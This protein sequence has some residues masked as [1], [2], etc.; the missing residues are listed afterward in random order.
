MR[1]ALTF[2]I[3]GTKIYHTI[4]DENGS[5]IG[6][7]EKY[8]TPKSLEEIKTIILNAVKKYENEVD[9][10]GISTAGAV[11][12]ENTRV[13]SSTGNLVSNYR[14]FDFQS[15]SKLPVYVENDANCAAWAEHEIGAS[16]NCPYSVMI[17]LGTGVGGG[18]IINNKIYKGKSG[19]AGEMH[20]KMYSDKRRKCTCGAY[21]C[22][23]AYA[24]GTGLKKTAEEMSGNP[25]ITTYDVVEGADKGNQLMKDILAKWQK[26]ITLGIIGLANIFDPDCIVLS[27]SMAQFVD[28]KEVEKE[29]N[30]EIVTTKTSIRLATAGNYSGMIGAGLLAIKSLEG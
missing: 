14:E 2:D 29:V 15:I 28:T 19:A 8:H 6:D 22:F 16:K 30:N 20:F 9:T 10:I 23:E 3:G 18:I 7:I 5:I 26:H 24:S 1:R 13:I 12:N 17:T 4:I 25:D 11:N 21:D 27:G